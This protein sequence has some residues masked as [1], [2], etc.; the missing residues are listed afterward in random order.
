M[1]EKLWTRNFVLAIG[2]NL[3]IYMVFYLLM[4]SMAL[5]AVQR[6]QAAD[7]AAGFASSAFVVGA[8]VSRF[9]AG[10]LLDAAGRR[11]VL[12]VSLAVF[13]AIS[14]LYIPAGSLAMLLVL[15]LLHGVAFGVGHTAVTAGAQALI[16]AAR[17]G[18]GTGYFA[19]ST[20]VATALGPLLAVLLSAG[21]EYDGVFLF[22]AGCSAAAFGVSLFLKLPERRPAPAAAAVGHG[23]GGKPRSQPR[24][25]RAVLEKVLEPAVL[26]IGSV[27]L[28]GCLAYSGVLSFL[29]SYAQSRGAAPSAALF[30]LVFAA[31]VLA[32]RLF[33]GRIQDRQGANV[34]MY[35]ALVMFAAGLALLALGT[36]GGTVTAAGILAGLGFG[37]MMP[38][39]QAIAVSQVPERRLGTAVATYFLMLDVGTGFGPVLLGLLLPLTGFPGMYVWLGVLMLACIGLY[40]GVHGRKRLLEV[41]A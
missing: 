1:Q 26:P 9:F 23:P 19:V 36:S 22:S 14:L 2:A 31:A 29:S 3:F 24:T 30:F 6:F 17:R 21:G 5:Y 7:T 39:T 28:V 11:R 13:A 33:A 20:S 4:T 18:E 34:V 35:P 8:L 12:M 10:P 25:P 16:P 40:Y 37:S 38:C 27:M 32:A 41:C 15:R